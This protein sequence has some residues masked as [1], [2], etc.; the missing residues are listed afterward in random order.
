MNSATSRLIDAA[1]RGAL[2]HSLILHGPSLETLRAAALAV[3]RARNCESGTGTDGCR[4]CER[5]DRGSHPDVRVVAVEDDRK[6]ISVEQIRSM[7]ADASF[8]PY[9]GRYKVFIVEQADAMSAGGANAL[10]KTLEEPVPSTSFL[11]LTRS[12]ELLLP[13]I[14]SRSQLLPVRDEVRG[15]PRQVAA[16]GHLP[17]QIARLV[18]EYPSL[19]PKDATAF[20]SA[21]NEG[22]RSWAEERDMSALLQMAARVGGLE[23]SSDMLAAFATALR[24]IATLPDEDAADPESL[25]AIREHLSA[26]SLLRAAMVAVRGSAR[27]QV[28]VDPRLVVEQALAELV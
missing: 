19:E 25:Q 20:V 21:V 4:S 17:L 10:L 16:R 14:R 5:I 2:H 11:L 26:E 22:L 9:E 6:L 12:P 7:V 1:R 28:N 3:A 8:R 24:D 13:T 23:P 18:S 27:L 15:N